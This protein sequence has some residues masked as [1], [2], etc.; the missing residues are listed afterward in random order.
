MNTWC[1]DVLHVFSQQNICTDDVRC[2]YVQKTCQKNTAVRQF[3][4]RF[5]FIV[6]LYL[7]AQN[8]HTHCTQL[9][10]IWLVRSMRRCIA[11]LSFMPI[12]GQFTQNESRIHEPLFFA[13]HFLKPETLRLGQLPHN[14]YTY[15]PSFPW[16]CFCKAGYSSMMP[17]K[18]KTSASHLC[19]FIGVGRHR[20]GGYAPWPWNSFIL[21]IEATKNRGWAPPGNWKLAGEPSPGKIPAYA[22]VCI[23]NGYCQWLYSIQ[24]ILETV[25]HE[26]SGIL[27][28][29][30]L[31]R[32]G[33]CRSFP[34]RRY[35]PSV[36][37]SYAHVYRRVVTEPW[38]HKS[39][40]KLCMVIDNL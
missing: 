28:L 3:C 36:E 35:W 40:S 38:W 32:C 19:A 26:A 31:R 33:Q 7:P 6:Q 4:K 39:L 23:H 15:I 30:K 27:E 24:G 10:R 21:T 14:K 2:T 37:Q 20:Q 1:T 9:A 11:A 25:T 17:R 5:S 18:T 8:S 12:K 34:W 29:K 22:L 16:I 13:C